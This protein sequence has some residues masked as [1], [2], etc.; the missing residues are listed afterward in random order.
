MFFHRMFSNPHNHISYVLMIAFRGMA[1]VLAL[2]LPEGQYLGQTTINLFNNWHVGLT[3]TPGF[4][5]TIM[6]FTR[7]LWV[8]IKGSAS[9]VI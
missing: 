2:W 3:L 1:L 7:P 5:Q 9:P 8:T 4:N 6:D